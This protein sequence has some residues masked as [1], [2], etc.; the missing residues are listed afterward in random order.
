MHI[1]DALEIAT[2]FGLT[3]KRIL[4]DPQDKNDKTWL[5]SKQTTFEG[6]FRSWSELAVSLNS[7]IH[8][9]GL[10]DLYPFALSPAVISKLGF[11]YEVI[12]ASN[13]RAH[14]NSSCD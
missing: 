3:G 1:Q 4:L 14:Q 5:S 9:M 7:F 2:D 13:T 11:I 8:S 10:P 6:V 12:S